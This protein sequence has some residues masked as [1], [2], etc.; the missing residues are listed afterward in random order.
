MADDKDKKIGEVPHLENVTGKE[1]IPVSANDEPRYIEV[2]QIREGLATSEDVDQKIE[3]ALTEGSDTNGYAFVDMGEAGI[4]ATCN[5]GANKPEEYGLYFAWGETEGYKNASSKTGG[6]AWTTY[7]HGDDPYNLTKYNTLAVRGEVDNLT[8]L[9]LVDDAAHV[10]MGGS[11]RIP[12]EHEFQKLIDNTEPSE[13]A[14]ENGWID[15]Y[16]ETGI[17]GLLLKSKTNGNT[18]FFPSAGY[19]SA[20]TTEAVGLVGSYWANDINIVS[21]CEEGNCLN[22]Q[23]TYCR[24]NSASTRY[25]GLSI[26]AILD[27]TIKSDKYLTKKEASE[28]YAKKEDIK[29]FQTSL[30]LSRDKGMF[31]LVQDSAV[32]NSATGINAVAFGYD[33]EAKGDYSTAIGWGCEAKNGNETSFGYYNNSD[34][35]DTTLFS[36]GNGYSSSGETSDARRHNAFEVKRSG[37]VLIPDTHAEG[38]NY[39][40]PM[41]NLQDKLK[42]IEGSVENVSD[43][44]T[45]EEAEQLADS[46]L[47]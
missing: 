26:R 15:N 30:P 44:M 40:K 2:E 11:W 35:D 39:R 10:D 14:N 6:F 47:F 23:K 33:S 24:P 28:T 16:K 9:E 18:I 25:R 20:G 43:F 13:G 22:F 21:K 8:T 1:K 32:G 42:E 34:T 31:S 45:P 29:D 19:T 38:E 36:I 37:N 3:D 41:I 7:K 4:W 46:I 17:S 27:P 5:V 12:T